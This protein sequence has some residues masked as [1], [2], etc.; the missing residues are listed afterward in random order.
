MPAVASPLVTERQARVKL[1][2]FEDVSGAGGSCRMCQTPMEPGVPHACAKLDYDSPPVPVA[3][4]GE[5]FERVEIGFARFMPHAR[6]VTTP[7][8]RDCVR[9]FMP[10]SD[11]ILRYEEA[12]RPVSEIA[13]TI[14]LRKDENGEFSR[15][16]TG[17]PAAKET[18]AFSHVAYDYEVGGRREDHATASGS[19]SPRS[20]KRNV[21]LALSSRKR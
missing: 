9:P 13:V 18:R 5:T 19:G 2:Y 20:K 6:P 17:R 12:T 21:R 10:S 16:D 4:R 3:V 11:F 15:T 8:S 7:K 14:E 1:D